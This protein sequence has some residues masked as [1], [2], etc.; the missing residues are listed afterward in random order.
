MHVLFEALQQTSL[1][2]QIENAAKIS[3]KNLKD[4]KLIAMQLIVYI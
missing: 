1:D 2:K 3:F 4:A